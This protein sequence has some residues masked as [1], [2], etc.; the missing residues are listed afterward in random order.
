MPPACAFALGRAPAERLPQRLRHWPSPSGPRARRPARR[1]SSREALVRGVPPARRTCCC[2]RSRR[3]AGICAHKHLGHEALD[4]RTGS[5]DTNGD[6]DEVA[7]GQEL[8]D[9]AAGRVSSGR[10]AGR[11]AGIGGH[12]DAGDFHARVTA[13]LTLRSSTSSWFP[14]LRGRARWHAP[15]SRC[16]RASPHPP[17][18]DHP[19]ESHPRCGDAR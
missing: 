1:S 16:A 4:L 5:I 19:C 14:S 7:V 9:T 3:R 8:D 2:Q 13:P 18:R 12:L 17:V 15:P 10:L 11:R 6:A